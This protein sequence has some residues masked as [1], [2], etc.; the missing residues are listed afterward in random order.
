MLRKLYFGCLQPRGMEA[1]DLRALAKERESRRGVPSP[2]A[3]A[4][5]SRAVPKPPSVASSNIIKALMSQHR[6]IK[7]ARSLGLVLS[8]SAP[9]LLLIGASR[10]AVIALL[11]GTALAR[12]GGAL[13]HKV[14][15]PM[16]QETSRPPTESE[17]ANCANVGLFSAQGVSALSACWG[18]ECALALDSLAYVCTYGKKNC[19]TSDMYRGDLTLSKITGLVWAKLREGVVR[20]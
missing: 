12:G 13:L 1:A 3:S 5:G 6:T 9:L 8:L 10:T 20:C 2:V 14:L 17:L 15:P 11:G 7:L 18:A 19:L 16:L 4:A